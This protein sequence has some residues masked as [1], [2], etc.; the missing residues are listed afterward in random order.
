MAIAR[1]RILAPRGGGRKA[2]SGAVPLWA[3]NIPLPH[4]AGLRVSRRRLLGIGLT[5]LTFA[6]LLAV[7]AFPVRAH[8]TA[9]APLDLGATAEVPN[10]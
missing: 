5:I 1:Q 9:L 4:D 6:F 10:D 2:S 7:T 3:G 8:E